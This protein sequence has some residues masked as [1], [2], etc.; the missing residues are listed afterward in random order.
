M[1]LPGI[2]LVR[3]PSV[4]T[5]F[6][7]LLLAFWWIDHCTMSFHTALHSDGR[8]VRRF[9]AGEPELAVLAFLSKDRYLE[10]RYKDQPF[11]VIVDGQIDIQAPE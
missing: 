4:G 11:V 7:S 5:R 6:P 2:L 10:W 1:F 8:I 9:G 3:I